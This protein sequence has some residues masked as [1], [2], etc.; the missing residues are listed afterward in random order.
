MSAPRPDA[1]ELLAELTARHVAAC[2]TESDD[3]GL[4]LWIDDG[5]TAVDIR[6]DIG[7]QLEA[8]QALRKLATVILAHA[9]LIESR[10]QARQHGPL[11]GPVAWPRPTT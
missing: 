8:A 3:R 10:E 4:S 6:H 7:D 9:D 11:T 5:E 1:I 2:S